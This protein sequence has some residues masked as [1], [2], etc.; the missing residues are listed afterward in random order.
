MRPAAGNLLEALPEKTAGEVFEVLGEAPGYRIERITS[1]GASSP[2]G[3]Y[4]E[5]DF[6]EWVAVLKGCAELVI[7]GRKT[8]L[9]PGDWVM[10][11]KGVRHRVEKTEDETVWLAFNAGR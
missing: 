8:A 5:Q 7:D 1:F 10:I 6:D 4:Y 11:P 9:G 2:E 3:F